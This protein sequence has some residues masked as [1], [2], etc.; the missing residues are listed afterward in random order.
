MKRNSFVVLHV[1]FIFPTS[2]FRNLFLSRVFSLYFPRA[3]FCFQSRLLT[4]INKSRKI[5]IAFSILALHIFDNNSSVD[6]FITVTVI[7]WK[8]NRMVSKTQELWKQCGLFVE[9][10]LV[11]DVVQGS[12]G[13]YTVWKTSLFGVILVRIQSECRKIWTRITPNTDTFYP[14]VVYF[15][16]PF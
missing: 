10:R 1:S 15:M 7:L 14:V 6:I 3:Y 16:R 11:L 4:H 12:C 13:T 5:I 8:S 9:I 2:I